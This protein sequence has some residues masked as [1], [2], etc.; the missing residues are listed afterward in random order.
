MPSFDHLICRKNHNLKPANSV[1]GILRG[2]ETSQTL[3][4]V[5]RMQNEEMERE[6]FCSNAQYVFILFC[7]AVWKCDF[8]DTK[9]CMLTWICL[10]P[11][12]CIPRSYT[13]APHP[14]VAHSVSHKWRRAFYIMRPLLCAR[15]TCCRELSNSWDE[16]LQLSSC[17]FCVVVHSYSFDKKIYN[18]HAQHCNVWHVYVLCVRHIHDPMLLP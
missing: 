13:S 8:W 17:T 5:V 11:G 10:T 3:G 16:P 7:F 9:L 18:R 6:W 1:L 14:K 12:Y 15:I 2:W 4:R